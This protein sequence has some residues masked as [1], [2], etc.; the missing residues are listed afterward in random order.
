MI[1]PTTSTST[2][3]R[4]STVDGRPDLRLVEGRAR[5]AAEQLPLELEWEV[6]PG[7]PAV[8]PVPPALRLV[9]DEPDIGLA[10]LPDPRL[11]AARLA[12]A[13]AEVSVGERPPGQLTRWVSRYELAKLTRR[14]AH[15]SR[16]P[17]ARAQ[18][19]VARKRVVKAVRT[20]EV[21]PGIVE[22]SAVLVGTDRA[23]AIAIRLEA[24]AGRWL[25]TAIE[26]R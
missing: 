17:S 10:D 25:A 26:M 22:T 9:T 18:Q 16:H 14:A 24:T 6:A 7:V 19:R 2:P 11:W 20:C 21:A 13:V 1:S 15:I 3:A 4:R 8:P 5:P 12:R 23:Q